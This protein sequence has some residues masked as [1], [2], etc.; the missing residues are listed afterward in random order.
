MITPCT[1]TRLAGLGTLLLVCGS[2]VGCRD[3]ADGRTELPIRI[4]ASGGTHGWIV[5]CGCSFDQLGGLPRRGTFLKQRAGHE[6]LVYVDTGG[7]ARGRSEYARA[8]FEAILQGEHEL[9]IVAHNVGADEL[10]LG[11][12]YLREVGQKIGVRFLASNIQVDKKPPFEPILHLTRAGVRITLLGLLDD[13][14]AGIV[15]GVTD[16]GCDKQDDGDKNLEISP[17]EQTLRERLASGE[18]REKA[19]LLVVLAY[20]PED[21]LKELAEQFPE[22]DLFLGGPDHPAPESV[23]RSDTPFGADD[24]TLEGQPI[25][26]TR[27]GPTMLL[28]ATNQGKFLAVAE[29]ACRDGRDAGVSIQNAT[30]VELDDQLADDPA[31]LKILDAYYDRLEKADMT[32]QASQLVRTMPGIG[33]D[34]RVAGSESCR[35]CHEAEYEVWSKSA[36]VSAWNSLEKSRAWVD[37]ACQSCHTTAYGLADGFRSACTTPERVNVGCE[38][39]HGPSAAH[40][41]KPEMQTATA[42]RTKHACQECHDHENSPHFDFEEYWKKIEHKA[43]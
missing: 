37:P 27:L 28:S 22:V 8:K 2:A 14:Y 24:A 25:P 5:P 16:P 36:H 35:T 26:P 6:H 41:A 10:A 15:G 18:L 42:G 1:T 33:A 11:V 38:S 29:L 20:M 30:I 32:A 40:V 4:V 21:R 43:S 17:P 23:S 13:S 12:D 7:A 39:C 19:D 3:A 34:A 31:Q 9:G